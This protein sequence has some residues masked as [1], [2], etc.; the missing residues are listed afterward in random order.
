[1]KKTL[2]AAVAAIGF[3]M[4]ASAHAELVTNGG[5]ETGNFSG[6][7]VNSQASGVDSQ[8]ANTGLYSAYFGQVGSPGHISQ[9]LSTIAGTLYDFSFAYLSDGS[10]PNNFTA[11]FD[12]NVVF[13]TINDIAH[14]FQTH[15]FTNLLASSNHTVIDFGI[16]NNPGYQ[17]LDDISVKASAAVPEPETLALLGLGLLGIAISRRKSAK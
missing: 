1:M 11:S 5:F 12:G 15:T 6:Y 16:Q 3:A 17:R 13:S 8:T 7:T 14:G 9:S 2:L 4:G 10:R